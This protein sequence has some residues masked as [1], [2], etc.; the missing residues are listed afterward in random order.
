MKEPEKPQ[1]ERKL[2]NLPRVNKL[3]LPSL[4]AP[5]ARTAKAGGL[6]PEEAIKDFEKDDVILTWKA[7]LVRWGKN[8][9]GE[10]CIIDRVFLLAPVCRK[11]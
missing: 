8:E 11:W 1:D 4:F 10:K 9:R 7:E 2:N 5:K 3:Y 6:S